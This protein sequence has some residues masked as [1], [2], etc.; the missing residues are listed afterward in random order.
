[1]TTGRLW[2]GRLRRSSPSEFRSRRSMPLRNPP[3]P[4]G[5]KVRP[6]AGH[7]R[8]ISGSCEYPPSVF[9]VSAPSE[10]AS[11]LNSSPIP[12]RSGIRVAA[13]RCQ[14]EHPTHS[15]QPTMP[16][17]AQQPNRLHPAEYFLDPLPLP[18]ATGTTN[19]GVR[20]S[21]GGIA[22]GD[23]N[24]GRISPSSYTGS[25]GSLQPGGRKVRAGPSH[26]IRTV[27]RR[28]DLRTGGWWPG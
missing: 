23:L 18:L 19:T 27:S 4:Q 12:K 21:A 14:R 24:V 28:K 9:C 3:A 6:R 1:M 22:G 20:S 17:L 5:W 25:H 8:L 2:S 11:R 10:S 7:S 13:R 15:L 16:E 26:L